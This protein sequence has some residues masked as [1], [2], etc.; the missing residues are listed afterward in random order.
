MIVDAEFEAVRGDESILVTVRGHFTQG[1]DP[2][3]D[4]LKWSLGSWAVVEPHE[5]RLGQDEVERATNALYREM[6]IA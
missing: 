5:F 1:G 3:F 2:S 4:R 6:R